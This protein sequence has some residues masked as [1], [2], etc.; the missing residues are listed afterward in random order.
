MSRIFGNLIQIGYVVTA[1]EAVMHYWAT[2]LGVGPWF[3]IERLSVPDFTY[4]G[5]PSAVDLSLALANSG[6]MQIELIQQRN[7]ASSM[8]RDFQ[9]D[10]D[11]YGEHVYDHAGV[12][13]LGYGTYDFARTVGQALAAGYWVAQQ[14][15]GGAR[16][17]FAY[18]RPDGVCQCHR[19]RH[20]R[21]VG[22]DEVGTVIEVMDLSY[23]RAE[24]FAGIAAAAR[25]WD[26]RDPVRMTLPV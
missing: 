8:Y 15:T 1:I 22:G 10:I 19:T 24:L 16:G 2:T 20:C 25:D 9:E 5:E 12:Q 6:T 13:H 21:F 17:P 3:Y 26:G 4:M 14:G 23:G 18:L 7:D 11:T